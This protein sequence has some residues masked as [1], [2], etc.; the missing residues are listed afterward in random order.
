MAKN[1]SK[2][3]RN[4][5]YV[6]REASFAPL[7]AVLTAQH[8]L[9]E[10]QQ[11]ELI[12]NARAALKSLMVDAKPTHEPLDTLKI[13]IEMAAR[14][15]DTAVGGADYVLDLEDALA[16]LII[17]RARQKLSGVYRLFGDEVRVIE[18]A[19]DLH[20]ALIELA[21]CKSIREAIAFLREH[22]YQPE[23]GR[24]A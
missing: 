9:D 8:S 22:E 19:L 13:A 24:A 12:G 17:C 18:S 1:K 14:L 7:N 21:T 16:I 15:S 5:K 6:P 3:P 23:L 20:D 2:K 4:K 10:S 11:A